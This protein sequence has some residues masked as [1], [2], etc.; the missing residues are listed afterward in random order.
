MSGRCFLLSPGKLGVQCVDANGQRWMDRER[1][2]HTRQG[3]FELLEALALSPGDSV[4]L[5][6]R[7]G[8]ELH[9]ALEQRLMLAHAGVIPLVHDLAWREPGIE[10]REEAAP[11]LDVAIYVSINYTLRADVCE[12]A[13]PAGAKPGRYSVPIAP[14]I[15]GT[16]WLFTQRKD[17]PPWRYDHRTGRA[18]PGKMEVARRAIW[19]LSFPMISNEKEP[20][21]LELEL[22]ADGKLEAAIEHRGEEWRDKRFARATLEVGHAAF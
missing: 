6:H 10:P 16:L 1:G 9:D 22:K 3:M 12:L 11:V 2:F 4:A 8:K 20:A 7:A 21:R 14:G 15:M 13:I 5:S 18:L 19:R 17:S